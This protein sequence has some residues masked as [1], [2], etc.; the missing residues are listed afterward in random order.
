MTAIP[1]IFSYAAYLEC[2]RCKT[3]Y[4]VT[5]INTYATCCNQPLVVKYD[6]PSGYYKEDVI[7]REKNMWRYFEVL[8]VMERKNIVTLGEGM[9]PL[10]PLEK[11]AALHGLQIY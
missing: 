6:H 9:T 4:P 11:S 3:A 10:L 7:F 5:D 8:P 1:E 2:A